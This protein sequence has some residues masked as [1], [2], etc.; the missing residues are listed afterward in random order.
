MEICYWFGYEFVFNRG[1]M[2]G[3]VLLLEETWKRWVYGRIEEVEDE[4]ENYYQ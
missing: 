4:V 2:L 3:L 1:N